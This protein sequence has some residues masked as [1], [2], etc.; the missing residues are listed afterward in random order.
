MEWLRTIDGDARYESCAQ[1]F[2]FLV[3]VRAKYCHVIVTMKRVETKKEI[4]A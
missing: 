4:Y 3:T 1:M 2:I